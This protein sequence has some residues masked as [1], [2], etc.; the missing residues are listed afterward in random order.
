[1]TFADDVFSLLLF[2]VRDRSDVVRQREVWQVPGFSSSDGARCRGSPLLPFGSCFT[3]LKT[4]LLRAFYKEQDASAAARCAVDR[5]RVSA[6]CRRLKTV[7]MNSSTSVSQSAG[8]LPGHL[9]PAMA[10]APRPG[11]W[12]DS[13]A[14]CSTSP[15]IVRAHLNTSH[16][17]AGGSRPIALVKTHCCFLVPSVTSPRLRE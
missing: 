15:I 16:Q 3:L 7:L 2:A 1:V 8:S 5:L 10:A 6:A 9:P 17:E 13:M 11:R 4:A 12:D 14:T